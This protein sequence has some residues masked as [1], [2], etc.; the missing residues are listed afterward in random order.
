LRGQ[1]EASLAQLL[2]KDLFAGHDHT[3]Q[4]IASGCNRNYTRGADVCK[5][6]Q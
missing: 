3:S 6:T 4:V 5:N 1:P 2:N